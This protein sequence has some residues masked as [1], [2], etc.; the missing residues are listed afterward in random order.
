MC[1]K[2][3]GDTDGKTYFILL[4]SQLVQRM[5]K[6]SASQAKNLKDPKELTFIAGFFDKMQ[7]VYKQEHGADEATDEVHRHV[8][9][10][11]TVM[12]LQSSPSQVEHA[13]EVLKT[14][15]HW[16]AKAFNL[17]KGKKILELASQNAEKRSA[18]GNILDTISDKI[19]WM[20]DN[21]FLKMSQT[22]VPTPDLG[23]RYGGMTLGPLFMLVSG[24]LLI[25]PV[26]SAIGYRHI[27]YRLGKAIYHR[28]RLRL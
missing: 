6:S 17:D 25:V 21:A 19:S 10:V 11:Q 24:D 27:G 26:S 18:L 15:E 5:L 12:D 16:L 14:S 20:E 28:L 22:A 3:L 2:H 13:C 4:L 9:A 23:A 8:M 7:E 1:L